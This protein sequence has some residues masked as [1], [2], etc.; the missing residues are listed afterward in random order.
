MSLD[1]AQRLLERHDVQTEMTQRQAELKA[2]VRATLERLCASIG[3]A[4]AGDERDELS[5]D[6]VRFSAVRVRHRVGECVSECG[7]AHRFSRSARAKSCS[8]ARCP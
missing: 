7:C 2:R 3:L 4:G 6:A 8:R 1:E 5:I